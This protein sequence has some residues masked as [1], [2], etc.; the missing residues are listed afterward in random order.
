MTLTATAV[1]DSI[2]GP[3][4]YTWY[5]NHVE[6]ADAHDSIYIESPLTV[7]GD[8]TTYEYSVMV[9]LPQS[10]CQ[11]VITDSSTVVVTVYANPTIEIAGDHNICGTGVGA[12]TIHLVANVNDSV[13]NSHGFTFEWRLFNVTV[14]TDTNVFDTVVPANDEPYIFTAIV[15]NENGCTMMS[16]PFEV[17]VHEAVEVRYRC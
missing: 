15:A 16:A 5:R 2:L 10:G 8:V 9:T 3:A 12:D 7:D 17:Y 11:S 6:I 14:G 4:T 13:T 1:Y